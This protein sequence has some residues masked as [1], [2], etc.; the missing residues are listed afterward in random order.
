MIEINNLTEVQIEESFI[1]KVLESVLKKEKKEGDISLVFIGPARMRKLNRKHL[2]KNRITDVLAFPA[3]TIVFEKFIKGD[4]KK[5]NDLGEIIICLR[6]VKKNSKRFKVS[7]RKELVRVIIHGALHLLGYQ[8]EGSE[9]KVKE[10][11]EKEEEYLEEIF[12]LY[13][14]A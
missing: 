13:V 2:G 10:M 4:L 11:K 5:T 7:F 9:R 14:Q 12:K 8:D 3:E 1:K 6:E